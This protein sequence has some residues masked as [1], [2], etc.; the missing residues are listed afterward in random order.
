VPSYPIDPDKLLEHAAQLA[1]EDAGPG[2]PSYTNHRR[3]VSSA[4]YAAFHEVTDE[5][6]RRLFPDSDTFQVQARRSVTHDAVYVVC[7]WL[8]GRAGAPQ[9][10]QPIVDALKQDPLVNSVA[11]SLIGLKE[12]RE[13][14]DYDHTRPFKKRETLTLLEDARATVAQL[15]TG[16]APLGEAMSLIRSRRRPADPASNIR[17]TNRYGPA[18]PDPDRA[19][20]RA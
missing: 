16:T 3:A 10:L 6:A 5:V 4:Y 12:A 15:K 14:A 2:R 18:D 9:H 11:D 19:P 13:E 17:Q 7:K 1:G 20:D 8:T